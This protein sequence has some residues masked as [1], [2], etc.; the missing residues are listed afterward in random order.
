V[1]IRHLRTSKEYEELLACCGK[2]RGKAVIVY[3]SLSPEETEYRIGTILT[4]KITPR[5]VDRNYLKRIIYGYFSKEKENIRKGNKIAIK[6]YNKLEGLKRSEKRTAIY[7]D[8]DL[9]MKKE[10]E[11]K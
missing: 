2:F 4:K 1:K 11:N 8:L 5:A 6:L 7:S 9:F 10:K 3:H